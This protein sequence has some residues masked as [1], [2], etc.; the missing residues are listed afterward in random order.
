[1]PGIG[2]L[3]PS[4]TGDRAFFRP[5][6][7]GL[8]VAL[9]IGVTLSFSTY[10]TNDILF[11]KSYAVKAAQVGV[12]PLYRD[13]ANLVE[14]HPQWVEQM[15]HPPGAIRLW[16]TALWVEQKTGVPFRVWFRLLTTLA[17]AAT[18][19]ALYRLMGVRRPPVSCSV[20]RRSCSPAFMETPILWSSPF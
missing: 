3:R 5:F 18:A 19:C 13:G 7:C 10:G 20:R 2:W 14:F 12:A 6:A 1:L 15:A 4:K 16:Q 8:I 9:A 11:F 17:H